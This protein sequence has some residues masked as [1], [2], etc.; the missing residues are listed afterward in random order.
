MDKSNLDIFLEELEKVDPEV[1]KEDLKV[2]PL[3]RVERPEE[4]TPLYPSPD[5]KTRVY[6]DYTFIR[7]LKDEDF[8]IDLDTMIDLSRTE[9]K[10]KINDGYYFILFM[11][12]SEI[13]KEYLQRWLEIAQIAKDNYCKLAYVNLTFEN[14]ILA[15]FK[16]LANISNINHPFFW[17]R[18]LETPYMMVYRNY[19]PVGF[20]NG[21]KNI[22]V[23][24]DFI[25]K[26][27]YEGLRQIDKN[28]ILRK[29][30]EEYLREELLESE[31]KIQARTLLERAEKED[32]L[33]K[34]KLKEIDPK[35]QEILEGVNYLN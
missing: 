14:K 1:N 17:A 26:D 12:E 9:E 33:E 35:N 21:P 7:E 25:I 30:S 6:T 32:K 23:I 20:Y 2:V 31:K 15:N 22:G 8:N 3:E 16:K 18:F 27:V 5:L 19:W 4:L 24:I 11:D 29:E 28:H 10:L 13:G 34:T